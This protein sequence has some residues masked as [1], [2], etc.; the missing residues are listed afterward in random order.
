MLRIHEIEIPGCRE[1]Q[2]VVHRDAR[3]QFVKVFH[4]DEFLKLGMETAFREEF[5]STSVQNV[6][7]GMHFQTPPC[8]HVKLVYCT[9]G[10]VFDVVVDIRRGS[11]RF[12]CFASIELSAEKGNALYIPKGIAHGFCTLSASATLVYKV[13]TVYSPT[14]DTGIR[15]DSIDI[16]WP[17]DVPVLSDRDRNLPPFADFDSPFVYEHLANSP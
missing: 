13:S 8:D 7:R 17:V 6:V 10:A 3:G 15:W 16:P 11:P 5:Y 4:A 14:H 12:G 1:I 9:A 2:P